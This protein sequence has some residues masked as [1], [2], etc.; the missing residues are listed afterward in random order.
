MKGVITLAGYGTR[1]LP[2]SKTVPREMSPTSPKGMRG[3]CLTMRKPLT[4]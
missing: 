4:W 2:A 1:F 3:F